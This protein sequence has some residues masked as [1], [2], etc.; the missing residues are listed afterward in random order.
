MEPI[1]TYSEVR[2]DAMPA[3]VA[4]SLAITQAGRGAFFASRITVL[5]A[6]PAYALPFHHQQP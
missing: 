6:E 1:A 4:P 2:F 5:M 3:T